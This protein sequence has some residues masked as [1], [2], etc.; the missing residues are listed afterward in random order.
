M[1]KVVTIEL[2]RTDIVEAIEN[3]LHEKGYKV[4]KILFKTKGNFIGDH[5]N[6]EG[7]IVEVNTEES[8]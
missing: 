1:K 5:I 3:L 8:I 4:K 6:V 7:A 2:E